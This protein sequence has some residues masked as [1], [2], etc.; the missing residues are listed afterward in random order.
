M[1]EV[2]VVD[3]VGAGVSAGGVDDSVPWIGKVEDGVTAD[4]ASGS[5]GVVGE[6]DVGSG[7]AAGV[8]GEDTA[9]SSGVGSTAG[10]AG[11]GAVGNGSSVGTGLTAPPESGPDWVVPGGE[12]FGVVGVGSKSPC[13]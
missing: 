9:G 1:V 7:L 6:K 2:G 4:A 10:V 3:G 5:D 13:V 12:G 8:A 11:E